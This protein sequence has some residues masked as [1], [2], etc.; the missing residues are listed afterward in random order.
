M[1]R[2]RPNRERKDGFLGPTNEPS[3]GF[4][5]AMTREVSIAR[6][7]E[8]IIALGGESKV[9]GSTDLSLP[10]HIFPGHLEAPYSRDEALL[11]MYLLPYM[12]IGQR[13]CY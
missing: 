7:G 6:A 3:A 8:D 2:S 11:V 10:F 1:W 4:R 9:Q 5:L 13:N 12:L